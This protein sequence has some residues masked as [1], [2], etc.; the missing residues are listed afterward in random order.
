MTALF[1]SHQPM[2]ASRTLALYQRFYA[3]NGPDL[4]AGQASD[5]RFVERLCDNLDGLQGLILDSYG[6]IG[7]GSAPIDGIVNLFDC[8]AQKDI[9]VIILTNGASRPAIGR[10][11]GYRNWG[12]PV[13]ADDIISSRDA[14]HEIALTIKADKP[15]ARFSYLCRNVTPF[16][17]VPGVPYG[18]DS[19]W[20]EADYFIF[21]GATSW[22]D[23]DQARLE[24]ALA[25][26]QASVIIGNPDVS[27]PVDGGFTFEPGFWGMKAQDAT[28]APL[29]MAG[30]PYESAFE[31]AFA[32]LEKK[33][34]RRLD[35]ASV[36]MV[37]DSLHTDILGAKTFGLRAILLSHYG[38]LAGRDIRDEA[39]RAGI[40][41]DLIARY[42]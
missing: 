23:R 20:D 15:E 6:V 9:P 3:E 27:A 28:G 26:T 35:K 22:E 29:I 18:D 38:L 41:P 25:K 33:A 11:Q 4:P 5:M 42:L 30:K 10:V 21:L 7:L 12:L 14:C 40:F 24:S 16:E 36:G 17:D 1:D 2:D 8:A 39:Q 32:A 19:A 34:G 13:T 37:G 31:I